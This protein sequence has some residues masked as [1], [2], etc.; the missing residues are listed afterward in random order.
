MSMPHRRDFLASS[1]AAV[2]LAAS[3]YE[4][5]VVQVGTQQRSGPHYQRARELLR[6]GRIGPIV[7]VRMQSLRNIMPGFGRPPDADPPDGLDW[8]FWLG[9]APQRR[10]NPQRCLYHFRW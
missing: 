8:D 10:Y 4:R 1:T 7:A 5:R 9:P 6:G 2:A 3:S